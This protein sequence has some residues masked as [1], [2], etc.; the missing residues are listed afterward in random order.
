[1]LPGEGLPELQDL[2]HGTIEVA[3][4]EVTLQTIVVEEDVAPLAAL[5]LAGEPVEVLIPLLRGELEVGGGV[6]QSP[7]L[8]LTDRCF[9][10]DRTRLEEVGLAL[11]LLSS[12]DLLIALLIVADLRQFLVVGDPYE[13]LSDC[14]THRLRQVEI[15]GVLL[16]QSPLR[17]HRVQLAE[18][19][20]APL[21]ALLIVLHLCRSQY[22]LR[23]LSGAGSLLDA[24]P[25]LGSAV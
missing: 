15:L 20:R 12:S 5:V 10:P 7:A 17:D 13:R 18:V 8:A 16:S 19:E 22:I 14:L 21:V 23:E 2:L 4:E 1:M 11:L 9:G 24:A 25:P 6:L 3:Q